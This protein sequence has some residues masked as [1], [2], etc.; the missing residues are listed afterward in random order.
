MR[1][2]LMVLSFVRINDE[3]DQTVRRHVEDFFR[4]RYFRYERQVCHFEFLVCHVHGQRCLGCT[5]Y[6]EQD[7]VC[8]GEAGR[9]LSVVVLDGEFNGFYFLEVFFVEFVDDARFH[10]WLR[11][12]DGAYGIHHRSQD[13]DVADAFSVGNFFKCFAQLTADECMTYDSIV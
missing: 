7:D 9:I 10:S 12:G 2:L 5:G 11:G 6:A 3:S 8:F 4:K 13:V 1:S